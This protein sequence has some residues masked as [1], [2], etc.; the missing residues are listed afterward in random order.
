[1]EVL[2]SLFCIPVHTECIKFG[3]QRRLYTKS[4]IHSKISSTK[5][6]FSSVNTCSNPAHR[7]M[8]SLDMRDK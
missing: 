2:I 3:F 6:A 8:F 4:G 5:I 1:M 7:H